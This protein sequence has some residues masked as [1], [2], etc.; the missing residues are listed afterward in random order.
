M[1]QSSAS[2][3]SSR[4]TGYGGE[5]RPKIGRPT[6]LPK[7]G[8]SLAKPTRYALLRRCLKSLTTHRV[9]L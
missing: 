9:P 4:A 6:A 1:L 8:T 5:A 7:L 2:S 3:A